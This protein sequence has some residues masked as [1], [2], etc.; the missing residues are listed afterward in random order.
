MSLARVGDSLDKKATL[1]A[2]ARKAMR[3]GYDEVCSGCKTSPYPRGFFVSL[4]L[5]WFCALLRP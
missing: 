1:E 3:G 4:G 2:K 5:C